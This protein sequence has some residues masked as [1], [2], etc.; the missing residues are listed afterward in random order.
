MGSEADP[1]VVDSKD[2][3]RQELGPVARPGRAAGSSDVFCMAFHGRGRST[4]CLHT[5]VRAQMKTGPKHLHS[6]SSAILTICCFAGELGAWREG[7][8]CILAQPGGEGLQKNMWYVLRCTSL[9]GTLALLSLS[10]PACFFRALSC[11]ACLFACS[12]VRRSH[13]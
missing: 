9:P 4:H 1:R 7:D 13:V 10:C 8:A 6:H 11:P 5:I 3:P 12:S 2:Q